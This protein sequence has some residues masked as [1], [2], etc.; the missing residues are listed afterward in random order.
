MTDQASNIKQR[1]EELAS[2]LFGKMDT[3]YEPRYRR[4]LEALGEYLGYDA[5]VVAQTFAIYDGR[6][7]KL[8]QLQV[9]DTVRVDDECTCIEPWALR[10]VQSNDD[11]QLFIE[12]KEG[13]HSLE[14]HEDT[15]NPVG[16]TE[17]VKKSDAA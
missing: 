5:K 11:G 9:G 14:A 3:E 1:I 10:T 12:C 17:I 13:R 15:G 4:V 16:I 8:D 7:V 2:K 6:G